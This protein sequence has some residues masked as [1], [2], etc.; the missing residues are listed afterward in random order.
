MDL[1]TAKYLLLAFCVLMCISLLLCSATK[2][3]YLGY[4]S[5][6]FAMA[7]AA[8]WITLLTGASPI[9][10]VLS[11]SPSRQV[12]FRGISTSPKRRAVTLLR[13]TGTCQ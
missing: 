4:L 10:R 3:I 5:I 12:Q 8:V 11:V 13:S 1:K 6:G 9:R 2:E 7:G